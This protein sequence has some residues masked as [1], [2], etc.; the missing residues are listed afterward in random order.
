MNN[1]KNPPIRVSPVRG[2]TKKAL[3]ALAMRSLHHYRSI[4]TS[5]V[6][7]ATVFPFAVAE[8]ATKCYAPNGLEATYSNMG[9]GTDLFLYA[10]P[11]GDDGFAT[12][13]VGTDFC[14]PNNLCY[15][16]NNGAPVAYRQ[17]CTDPTW[18]SDNCSGLCRTAGEKNANTSGAVS[19]YSLHA[20]ESFR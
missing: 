2:R 6:F 19:V 16:L 8:D 3:E 15:N 11:P 13:C 5:V 9:T 7:W 14:Q 12:C 18:E 1:T 10:C 20:L 4:L 17:Y